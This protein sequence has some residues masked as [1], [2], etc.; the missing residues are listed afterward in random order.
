MKCLEKMWEKKLLSY[1]AK[2][3]RGLEQS[4]TKEPWVIV[5][6]KPSLF[7]QT[8]ADSTDSCSYLHLEPKRRAAVKNT[9]TCATHVCL[10]IQKVCRGSWMDVWHPHNGDYNLQFSRCPLDAL[11]SL[12]FV[13]PFPPNPPVLLSTFSC[14]WLYLYNMYPKLL[15]VSD[16]HHLLFTFFVCWFCRKSRG[17]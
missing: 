10:I 13:H 5:Q 1:L 3:Y 7:C 15:T 9:Q 12:L 4:K 2:L 14:L 8:T 17:I 16:P 6:F 11:S